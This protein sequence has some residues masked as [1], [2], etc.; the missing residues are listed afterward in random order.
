MTGSSS[1]LLQIQGKWYQER[2]QKKKQNLRPKKKQLHPLISPLKMV[3]FHSYVSLPEGVYIY[4]YFFFFLPT[5]I[6]MIGWSFWAYSWDG[7]NMV[8]VSNISRRRQI[9]KDFSGD[10]W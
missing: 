7:L 4:I 5:K 1:K 2:K 6:G 10:E 8:E 9:I 3:I